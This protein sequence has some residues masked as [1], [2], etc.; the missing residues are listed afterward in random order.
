M[1][2]NVLVAVDL[3]HEKTAQHLVN[4][5]R[6]LA[7]SGKVTVLH[8]VQP[9]PS[10]VAIQAPGDVVENHRKEAASRLTGLAQGS[11][12]LTAHGHPATVI[13]DEAKRLGCDAIVMGSHRPGLGDYLL[14]STAARVVRHSPC[15]VVVDRSV[16]A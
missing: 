13:L 5:G 4:V 8:V 11:E 10:Y 7:G 16:S 3:E 15:T 6:F 14:G 1:Y 9:L 2:A 12:T